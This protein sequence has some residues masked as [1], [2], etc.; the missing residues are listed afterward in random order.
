[1]NLVW[2]EGL[3][4]GQ[5]GYVLIELEAIAITVLDLP[6]MGIRQGGWCICPGMDAMIMP[7]DG[8]HDHAGDPSC[9]IKPKRSQMNPIRRHLAES[10]LAH[11]GT[12]PMGR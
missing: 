12:G 11:S 8:C 4:R 9:G 2:V 7:G 3:F 5:S 1:M 6:M 10:N